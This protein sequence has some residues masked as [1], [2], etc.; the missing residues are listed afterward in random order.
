MDEPPPRTVG[1]VAPGARARP[2]PPA[3]CPRRSPMRR[4]GPPPPRP[5]APRGRRVHGG[6]AG[7]R[8]HA[9]VAL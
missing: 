5:T 6:T 3:A 1:R 2:G 4:R 7:A 8:P 9:R